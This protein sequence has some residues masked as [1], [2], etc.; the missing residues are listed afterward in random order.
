MPEFDEL[1]KALAALRSQM[2]KATTATEAI[3]RLGAAADAMQK[4]AIAVESR[5]R[6]CEQG[7]ATVEQAIRDCQ[8]A[9]TALSSQTTEQWQVATSEVLERCGKAH[10]SAVATEVKRAGK[11][12]IKSVEE[13]RTEWQQRERA[14]RRARKWNAILIIVAILLLVGLGIT[15][16]VFAKL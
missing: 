6:G 9:V 7:I 12:F 16:G 11:D 1:N 8:G 15:S 14:L 2:D 4:H 3:N 13:L 5:L 10:V